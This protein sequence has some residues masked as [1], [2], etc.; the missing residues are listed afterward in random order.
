MFGYVIKRL[1]LVIPTLLG[2]LTLNFFMPFEVNI[3]NGAEVDR[4]V[5]IYRRLDITDNTKIQ[6]IQCREKEIDQK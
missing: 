3:N 5:E 6:F 1:L 2:I 4:A